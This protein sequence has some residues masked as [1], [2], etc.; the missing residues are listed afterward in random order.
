MT[1]FAR[2]PV[3]SPAALQPESHTGGE[4]ALS[5]WGLAPGRPVGRA[6]QAS[7]VFWEVGQGMGEGPSEVPPT[8]TQSGGGGVSSGTLGGTE[9]HLT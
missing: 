7:G 4:W 9:Q 2:G 5:S 8:S 1:S 3:G 6:G